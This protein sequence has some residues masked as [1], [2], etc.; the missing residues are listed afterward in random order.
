MKRFLQMIVWLMASVAANAFAD[1][2][3]NV[4]LTYD[5]MRGNLKVAQLEEIYTRS[6]DRYTLSS[7]LTPVGIL[8]LF[9]PD[10]IV[11]TSQG[12][13]DA[14]GLKP[15]SY[16][17]QREHNEDKASH[18]DFAWDVKQL[19]LISQSQRSVL[20]LPKGTQDRLSAMYQF[21]FSPVQKVKQ[22]S[23]SMTNGKKLDDYQY[24]VS[25]PQK[26]ATPAGEFEVLYLDNHAKPGEH[27]SE[28]W[29]ATQRYNLP[30]KMTIT[31]KKGDQLTQLLTKLQIKP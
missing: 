24:S 14:A 7:T 13:V 3:G 6:D 17:D 25:A 31:D 8:A 18:A 27:R 28:I 29:L 22:I 10:K 1:T 19:T 26:M 11:I 12:L 5:V 2:P 20:V 30:I 21:M 23:F 16:N 15:L 9:K 4:Y